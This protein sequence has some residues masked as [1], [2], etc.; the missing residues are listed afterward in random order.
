MAVQ[1]EKDIRKLIDDWADLQLA[2]APIEAK[3][4]ELEKEIKTWLKRSKR[5]VTI[6]GANAFARR[7][8]DEKLGSRVVEV[9]AFFAAT[10]ELDPA[11]RDECLK[12][13]IKKA[14]RLLGEDALNKIATRPPTNK[15]VIELELK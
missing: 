1:T 10:E 3:A 15:F 4:A 9:S 13:E 5:I 12:V 14:E 8:K 2:I 7:Y 11:D 6:S